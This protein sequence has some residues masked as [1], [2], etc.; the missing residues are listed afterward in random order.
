LIVNRRH[1]SAVVQLAERAALDR[2]AEVEIG[3]GP[4]E[5]LHIDRNG[6][7]HDSPVAE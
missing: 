6:R 1:R 2:T 5:I 7:S 3:L 4:N